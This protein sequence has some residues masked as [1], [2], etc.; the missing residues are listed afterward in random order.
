MATRPVLYRTRDYKPNNYGPGHF[1]PHQPIYVA[2]Y[3]QSI[4]MANYHQPRPNPQVFILVPANSGALTNQLARY[5]AS[6]SPAPVPPSGNPFMY[7]NP[8]GTP[9]H[10]TPGN[11]YCSRCGLEFAPVTNFCTGCGRNL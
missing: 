11:K 7:K 2:N 6:S 4:C 9:R 3:H 10:I 8:D 1:C 5:M